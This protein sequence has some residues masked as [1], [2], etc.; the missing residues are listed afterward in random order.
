MPVDSL[1][2]IVNS[3][4]EV[5]HYKPR[6]ASYYHSFFYEGNWHS[7]R[8]RRYIAGYEWAGVGAPQGGGGG[9]I[10]PALK[11]IGGWG[12]ANKGREALEWEYLRQAKYNRSLSGNYSQTVNHS[13]RAIRNTG[14]ALGGAGIIVTGIDMRV[15]GINVSNSLDLVMG[16]IAFIPGIGWAISGT[17][18]LAN[19]TTQLVTNKS[20]GEH[21]QEQFTNS[22]ATFKPWK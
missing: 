3:H 22:D 12:L 1:Q 8:G 15:N 6:Y 18:F 2:Y 5:G 13:I 10:D 21:I 16:G 19:I 7:T 14:R 9:W 11:T 4:G 17:Y 20:I